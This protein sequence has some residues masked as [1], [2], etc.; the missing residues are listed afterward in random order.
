MPW[1][2][3][4]ETV[5][6]RAGATTVA[7]YVKGQLVKTH[8]LKDKGRQTDMGDYP[9]DKVAFL[10]RTPTWCRARAVELAPAPRR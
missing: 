2:H 9:S 1:R 4:G 5:D 8:A 6:A 7:I 10:M 3:I